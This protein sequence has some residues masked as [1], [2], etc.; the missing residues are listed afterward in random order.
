MTGVQA[1]VFD[2]G[3]TLFDET[4]L[5]AEWSD[6]LGVP[7]F[8]FAA[9]L[10]GLI[11]QGRLHTNVFA[12]LRPGLDLDRERET[13]LQAGQHVAFRSTDLYPDALPALRSLK[14]AGYA[15]GVVGNQPAGF[16]SCL[17]EVDVDIDLVA[18]S[19]DLGV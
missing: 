16:T 6:W 15:V 19:A 17:S 9:V 2:A 1:V 5:W 7:R 14:E 3:E 13:R 18:T 4:R 10:G 11:A 12:I 8:T